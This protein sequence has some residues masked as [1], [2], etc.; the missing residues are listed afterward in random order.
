MRIDIK[1]TTVYLFDE[2]SDDTKQAVLEKL[3]DT[4]VNYEW[5]G[6]IYEDAK[7]VGIEITE[8]DIDRSSFCHGNIDDAMKTANKI[9]LVHG[10]DYK[11]YK[12]ADAFLC[13]MSYL[14]DDDDIAQDET[15][16]EFGRSILE[17]YRI[18]LQKEYEYLTSEEVIVEMI[19][20]NEFEFTADGQIYCK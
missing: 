4:N 2:L 7:N 11:T 9:L 13:D 19:K 14:D 17:D 12:T 10:K 5:W 1:K 16:A 15:E 20:V 18:I 3:Y 8:F 6:S